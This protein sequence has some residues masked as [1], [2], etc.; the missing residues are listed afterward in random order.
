M[1]AQKVIIKGRLDFGTIR[2]F[3]KV[4]TLFNHR[5]ENFY[6]NDTM[7]DAELMFDQETHSFVIPRTVTHA[8]PKTWN[9]TISALEFIAQF[10]VTGHVYVFM[11]EGGV[12]SKKSYIE[13]LNEKLAVRAYQNSI[14]FIKDPANQQKAIE[15]L[16]EAITAYDKHAMA[17]EKRAYVKYL[18]KQYDGALID[19]DKSIN[20]DDQNPEPYVGKAIIMSLRDQRQEALKLLD[21]ALTLCFPLQPIYWKIKRIKGHLHMKEAEAVEAAQEFKFFL[22]RKFEK[23]NP[24]IEWRRVI[25]WDYANVLFELHELED[26]HKWLNLIEETPV[27]SKTIDEKAFYQL[28]SKVRKE[29]GLKSC[30]S[31]IKKIK[32]I[33]L[34]S[35]KDKSKLILS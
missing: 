4:L 13:P 16:D 22:N 28:R 26:A 23:G 5:L 35:K 19:Y 11:S 3:E 20:A 2:S 1:L 34:K 7:I 14:A 31:D 24:N 15:Y 9:N 8:F 32:E 18:L 12:I 29:L 10:A 30:D 21:H 27:T 33:D 6:K 17:Y 25:M